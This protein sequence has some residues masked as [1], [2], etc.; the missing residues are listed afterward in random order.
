M[1]FTLINAQGK[2]RVFFIKAVAEL[3]QQIEGGILVSG[4]VL[5]TKEVVYE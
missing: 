1:N 3:Y 4:D 2:I 5:K